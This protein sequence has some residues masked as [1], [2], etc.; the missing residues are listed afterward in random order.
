[1]LR[2]R[3]GAGVSCTGQHLVD[4]NL[5][6]DIHQT[7]FSILARIN[8]LVQQ[9]QRMGTSHND[10]EIAHL[11]ECAFNTIQLLDDFSTEDYPLF[12][13]ACSYAQ[14]GYFEKAVKTAHLITDKD[15]RIHI[16]MDTPLQ[17]LGRG[18]VEKAMELSSLIEAHSRKLEVQLIMTP[19][20]S[21]NG[22]KSIAM[23]YLRS[24]SIYKLIKT[25]Q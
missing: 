25:N 17:A 23:D 10:A 24:W 13:I 8:R 3:W 21:N 18:Y 14:N 5:D 12:Q 16:E 20:L 6:A 22:F 9:D 4:Q 19:F 11:Y 15:Y 1:L 7:V 2:D